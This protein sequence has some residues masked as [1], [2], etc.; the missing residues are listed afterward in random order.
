MVSIFHRL[1]LKCTG[2]KNRAGNDI[3]KSAAI[4]DYERAKVG[5]D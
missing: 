4:S 5:I 2:K 1:D 3:M